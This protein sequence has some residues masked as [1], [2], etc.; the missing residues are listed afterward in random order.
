MIRTKHLWIRIIKGAVYKY[1]F[2][3]FALVRANFDEGDFRFGELLDIP[4]V[5]V[6]LLFGYAVAL[7]S[8]CGL[9]SPMR[10]ES[11]LCLFSDD[12]FEYDSRGTGVGFDVVSGRFTGLFE[13]FA[14]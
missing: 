6:T 3:D 7:Y 2:N 10:Q 12:F 13:S 1:G 14:I 9:H 11:V 4:F 5:I 8:P